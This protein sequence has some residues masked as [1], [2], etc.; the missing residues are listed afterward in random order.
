M[1]ENRWLHNWI[2][3]LGIDSTT[4]LDRVITDPQ[5]WGRVLELAGAHK[6]E[7]EVEPLG[8]RS[9]SAGRALD[10]TGFL[11]CGHPDCLTKQV[12]HLFTHVWHYF[13]QIA[14]VGGD[15][16]AVLEH[17]EMGRIERAQEIVAGLTRV[18]LHARATGVDKFLV[19]VDKPPACHMHWPEYREDASLR[20]PDDVFLRVAKDMLRQSRI[21]LE[22]SPSGGKRFVL[23][24]SGLWAGKEYVDASRVFKQRVDG[25][26]VEESV[27]IKVLEEYAIAAASDLHAAEQLGSPIGAGTELEARLLAAIRPTATEDQIAFNV[28][29]PVVNGLG[30]ADLAAL[31]ES[32]ED[33]FEAFRS[34]L[35][36]AMRTRLKEDGSRDP[37]A[38]AKAIETEV[39]EPALVDLRRRLTVAEKSVNRKRAVHAGLAGLSTV[40]GLLGGSAVAT[41]LGLAAGGSALAVELKG[42]DSRSDAESSKMYFLWQ[43]EKHANGRTTGKQRRKRRR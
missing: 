8:K 4:D 40:C 11:A 19:F 17:A 14:V 21:T 43:V 28:T 12:D 31:R 29:L 27:V 33:A 39:L 16:H 25:V 9:I 22:S 34:A 30:A 37:V 3:E 2:D 41:G 6:D 7:P 20:I 24:S 15:S 10:L 35:S 1:R 5:H 26:S 32:E 23:R 38:I 13:D 18:L 42:I 36:E